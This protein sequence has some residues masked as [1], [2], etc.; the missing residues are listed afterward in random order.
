MSDIYE[1]MHNYRIACCDANAEV[2][3]LKAENAKLKVLLSAIESRMQS[4]FSDI[5]N[6][7]EALKEPNE[8]SNG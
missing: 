1:E 5:A 4:V 2:R 6:Y 8:A 7:R 3:S